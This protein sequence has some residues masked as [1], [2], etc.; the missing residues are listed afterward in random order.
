MTEISSEEPSPISFDP[1]EL[2]LGDGRSIL[3]IPSHV[4]GMQEVVSKKY[5]AEEFVDSLSRFA[6]LV[7]EAVKSATP[8]RVKLEFGAQLTIKSGKVSAVLVDMA[9]Q[10]DLKVTLE[11]EPSGSD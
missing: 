3:F 1:V 11:W 7:S 6:N 8:Q 9:G 5:S 10:C 4:G 2:D